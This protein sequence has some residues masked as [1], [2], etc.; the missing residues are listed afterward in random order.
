MKL[1]LPSSSIGNIPAL[2]QYHLGQ[3]AL[4]ETP[5]E[6]TIHLAIHHCPQWSSAQP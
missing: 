3:A 4:L 2:L 6:G 5:H 1:C